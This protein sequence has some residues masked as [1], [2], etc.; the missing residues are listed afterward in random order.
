MRRIRV[1]GVLAA[2]TVTTA[3][4]AS[5]GCGAK[6]QP[7][8]SPS[9]QPT[10]SATSGPAAMSLQQ[11]AAA[12]ASLD[13]SGTYA[14]STGAA[15]VR[16]YVTPAAYRVDVA[17]KADT[18]S[19]YGGANR[20]SVA[21][22]IA[23]GMPTVCYT[24]AAPGAAVPTAFDAGVQRVFTRD[25]PALA[26]NA[27]GFGITEQR[28]SAAV[29]AAA[30]SA[31][32]FVVTHTGSATPAVEQTDAGTY[33]LDLAGLPVQ[34]VFPSGKLTLASR[35]AAPTTAQLTPPVAPRP[36][37]AGVN[38]SPAPSSSVPVVLPSAPSSGIVS[39]SPAR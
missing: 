36:L 6:A 12:A 28:P 10:T 15:R 20:P 2:V 5:A 19:L 34:L 33:C 9:N 8:A 18:A 14:V 13:F 37:P 38:T 27:A 17:E 11:R 21:C 24:V 30:P 16:V 22:T 35:G 25:L 4:A 31:R 7:K 29:L 32:C 39:G 26:S 3:V 23:T 1:L